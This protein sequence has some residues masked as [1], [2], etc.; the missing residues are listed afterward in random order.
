[1]KKLIVIFIF[2]SI[3]STFYGKDI[4]YLKYYFSV[5]GIRAGEAEV[6]IEPFENYII[7]N[8]KVKTY[9]GLNLVVN[10]DDKVISKI[11]KKSLKT[12]QRDTVSVGR[13]LKDTN[14]VIFD[15]D[16]T[17]VIIDSL[18]FG[19]IVFPNTNDTINDLPTEILRVM[20]WDNVPEKLTVNF[21]E[22][23]NTRYITLTRLKGLRY[24]VQEIKNAYIELTNIG[25]KFIFY[26]AEIPVFYLFPFGDIGLYVELGEVGDK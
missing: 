14:I 6:K 17:N 4:N 25:D 11:D 9:P 5:F 1:M 10:L 3:F 2:S 15:R 24:T 19:K 21:L 8:S 22:V 26:R 13:S 18:K 7:A 12:L 16:K 20:N 23:T